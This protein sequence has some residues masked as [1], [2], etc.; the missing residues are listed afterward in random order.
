MLVVLKT[1]HSSSLI[2]NTREEQALKLNFRRPTQS[3][4]GLEEA[5]DRRGDADR[6]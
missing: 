4:Q 2:G 3:K 1:H 6:I 5:A